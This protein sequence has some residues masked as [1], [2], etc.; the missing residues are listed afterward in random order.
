MKQGKTGREGNRREK[1][2]IGRREGGDPGR[3]SP[4][5]GLTK[6]KGVLRSCVI[7][8]SATA[9]LTMKRLVAE[10]IPV[11]END[12]TDENI[13]KEREDDDE[14]VSHDKQGFHRGVL[15]LG[16]IAPLRPTKFCRLRRV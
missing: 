12:M 7:M 2:E 8:M 14:R 11:L 10:C 1:G 5:P 6:V 16:P 3:Q 13:A 15:G 4:A 9:K